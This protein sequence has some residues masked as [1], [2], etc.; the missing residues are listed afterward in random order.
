MPFLL[1][2]RGKLD[3]SVCPK[4]VL[5]RTVR[6]IVDRLYVIFSNRLKFEMQLNGSIRTYVPVDSWSSGLASEQPSFIRMRDIRLPCVVVTGGWHG[7]GRLP[8]AWWL[9]CE[10]FRPM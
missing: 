6:R 9:R 10:D 5:L 1:I 8:L 7:M 4:Y 2:K 3:F